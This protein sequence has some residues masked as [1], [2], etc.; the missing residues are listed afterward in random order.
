MTIMAV[1]TGFLAQWDNR[2]SLK[3][4]MLTRTRHRFSTSKIFSRNYLNHVLAASSSEAETSEQNRED[5]SRIQQTLADLDALLGINEEKE[6]E[7]EAQT[8]L[9]VRT[10]SCS[11]IPLVTDHNLFLN[12][13]YYHHVFQAKQIA[14]SISPDALAALAD[15]ETKRAEASDG[16][17]EVTKKVSDSIVRCVVCRSTSDYSLSGLAITLIYNNK[18]GPDVHTIVFTSFFF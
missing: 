2:V 3:R 14:V 13:S 5:S 10:A 11:A 1:R 12:T 18:Y 4:C 17:P 7:D 9:E 15:A 16:N 6:T 8:S